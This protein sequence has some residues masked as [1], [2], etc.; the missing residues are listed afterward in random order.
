LRPCAGR[1]TTLPNAAVQRGNLISPGDVLNIDMPRRRSQDAPHPASE[2]GPA[3]RSRRRRV[4]QEPAEGA[5]PAEAAPTITAEVVLWPILI[6]LALALRLASLDRLPLTVSE[7]ARAFSAWLVSEGNVPAGWPGDMSAALTSY[8]FRI[9]GSGET[10]ARIVPAVSGSALVV[11]FW[12]AGRYVGR[13]VALLA[14]ALIALSPLAVYTS[15]SAFGLALGGFLSMVMV[16]SLLAYLEQRRQLPVLILAG[17]FGLALASDPIATSTAIALATFVAVEAAWRGKGAVSDAIAT[18]RSTPDHWFPAVIALAAALLA[19]VAQFGTDIDRFTLPGLRQWAD[20]F[21]LPRDDLPWHYQLSVL[22]GYE[23][24]LFLAGAAACLVVAYRWFRRSQV[25]PLVQRL[26][27]VWATVA[28]IVV[29]FATRRDSGQLLLLLLPL[30]LLAATLIEELLSRVDWD[31]LKRWWPAVVLALALTAYAL[32][33]LSRWA[34]EGS[35]ISEGDKA[36][37][38][39]ALIGAAAIVA[40]GF[41]YLGR[42]GLALALP[43][44]AA[45]AVPF[46]IHSSLSLAFSDGAEFAADPRLTSRIEPFRAEALRLADDRAASVTLDPQLSDALGWPL[47]N[48]GVLIGDP[49]AGSLFVTPAD[50]EAPSGLEPLAGP[51]QVAEGWVPDDL[52]PLPAWRWFAYRRPYG[53]L[54]TVDVEILAPTQ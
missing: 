42:N 10:V 18:F 9:F 23:W 47:R 43:F 21:A 26:L 39:L 45:L 50:R 32:L 40:G 5:P 4:E 54:S 17:A 46:L 49:P 48:S 38:I 7:S 36:L 22:F 13:G 2:R 1:P 28:L 11:S 41:Y 12:L 24:P 34:R 3:R 52:D 14:C 53:N 20:M 16:L 15:R 44:A 30:S 8:L 19:G 25:P 33:Q 29:A 35:L 37:L 51:W 31:V 27:L 6:G